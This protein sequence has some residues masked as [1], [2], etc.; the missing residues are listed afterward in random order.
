MPNN[1]KGIILAGGSGTRLTPITSAVSKQLLPVYDKPMIYYPLCTLMSGGIRE[2]LIITKS[3]DKSA[4]KNLLGDGSSF[5]IEIIYKVQDNPGGIAE[6]FLIGEDFI[7][8]SNTALILG[9]NLFHGDSLKLKMKNASKR[10]EGATIFAYPVNDPK[11]YGVVEFDKEGIAVEIEEKPNNPKSNLAVTGLY[12]YD[13]S[14]VDKAKSL[15]PSKRGELEITD[16]NM[17][18]MKEKQLKVESMDSGMAWL[19]TGT[20]DSLFEASGYIYT[21]QKRQGLKIGCPEEI[22]W[23]NKW[24]TTEKLEEISK[25]YKNIDYSNYLNKLFKNEIY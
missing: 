7:K 23:R 11:R 5:G 12:F 18:Y 1:R 13:S 17:L 16:L 15:S 2:I 14:V 10:N 19:D 9:D 4:F 25:D 8:N 22:A 3:I 20:F 6:A 24:I 21:L